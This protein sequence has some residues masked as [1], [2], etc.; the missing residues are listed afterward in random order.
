M[1]IHS[2]DFTLRPPEPK[3]CQALYKFKN[4]P[5]CVVPARGIS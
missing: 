4:D 2:P 3:D 1:I 5:D